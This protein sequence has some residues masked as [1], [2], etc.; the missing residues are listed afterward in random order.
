L[1][2]EQE[3]HREKQAAIVSENLIRLQGLSDEGAQSM[4]NARNLHASELT[5]RQNLDQQEQ[6]GLQAKLNFER[7]IISARETASQNEYNRQIS[8]CNKK[9]ASAKYQ[10]QQRSQHPNV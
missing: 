7:Q 9:D 2:Q 4:A 5:Y 3:L 1:R 10:A 6:A 8:L